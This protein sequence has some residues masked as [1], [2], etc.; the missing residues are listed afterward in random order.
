MD[1]GRPAPGYVIVANQGTGR[2]KDLKAWLDLA[3]DHVS[4]LP[5]KEKK[6]PSKKPARS[7]KAGK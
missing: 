1:M 6:P 3:V 5:A 2:D 4:T 7:R